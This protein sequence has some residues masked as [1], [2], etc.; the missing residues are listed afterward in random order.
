MLKKVKMQKKKKEI[1]ITLKATDDANLVTS[2]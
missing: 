1:Q 2:N